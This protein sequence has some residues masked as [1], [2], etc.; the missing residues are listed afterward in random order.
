MQ[1]EILPAAPVQVWQPIY[2]RQA[3]ISWLHL[4]RKQ[5]P[6]KS[7]GGRSITDAFRH[8]ILRSE[9]TTS[10]VWAREGGCHVPAQLR[11]GRPTLFLNPLTKGN[12]MKPVIRY[13]SQ[14]LFRKSYKPN[15]N[16]RIRPTPR[17][18]LMFQPSRAGPLNKNYERKTD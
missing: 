6:F 13:R 18:E 10:R 8:P 14:L 3:D 7:N 2:G 9:P 4:S 17:L 5:D 16:I 11:P 12:I 1:V 15:R